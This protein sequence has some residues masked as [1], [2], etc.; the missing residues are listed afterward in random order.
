MRD[1]PRLALSRASS[2]T[3]GAPRVVL[4][5]VR[6]SWTRLAALH[7][8]AAQQ[9]KRNPT[10]PRR[11]RFPSL[12]NGPLH[13]PGWANS[14]STRGS[15]SNQVGAT[16]APKYSAAAH[17]DTKEHFIDPGETDQDHVRRL[18]W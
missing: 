18:K 6:W 9:P 14:S 13:P 10:P 3:T 17:D 16:L 15:T 12:L 7:A 4:R 2:A 8:V 11:Q 5:A 1:P